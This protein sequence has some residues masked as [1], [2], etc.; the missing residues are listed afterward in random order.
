MSKF[1]EQRV[2]VLVDIQNLYYSS[3]V[4][5][6]KKVNAP[7]DLKKIVINE[8]I[9]DPDKEDSDE[10]EDEESET[11][12]D[13]KED[14]GNSELDEIPNSMAFSLTLSKLI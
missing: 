2:G 14:P 1:K 7:R 5:H 9:P 12:E 8:Y 13:K 10:K 4:I 11:E 3:K 6:K